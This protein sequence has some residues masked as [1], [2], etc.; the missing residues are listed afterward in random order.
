MKTK[1]CNFILF[2]FRLES[3]DFFV[4]DVQ[5]NNASLFISDIKHAIGAILTKTIKV[6]R[7]NVYEQVKID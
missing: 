1:I 7:K 5:E 4:Q 6:N 2:E 3:Y